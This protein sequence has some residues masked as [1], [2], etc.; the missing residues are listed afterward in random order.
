METN[1]RLRFYTLLAVALLVVD[2]VV[3]ILVKTH[4]QIGEEIPLLGTWC[5][6]HFTENEG[7]AFGTS[8][9]GATGKVALTLFRL[10]ASAAIA[11]FVVRLIRKQSRAD[12]PEAVFY[13]LIVLND[14]AVVNSEFGFRHFRSPWSCDGFII[15]E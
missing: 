10:V 12:S 13:K 11:W 3:K 1:K 5:R 15:L 6:L 14:F 8:F 2:Q 4:M 9:G 7:F